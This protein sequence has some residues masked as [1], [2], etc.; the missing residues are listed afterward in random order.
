MSESICCA[1]D[2][3]I[4]LNDCLQDGMHLCTYCGKTLHG[5][6][7]KVN[8]CYFMKDANYQFICHECAKTH[9][10]EHTLVLGSEL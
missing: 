7:N 3:P 2:L 9:S 8:L 6:C 5:V 1:C 4:T 10:N